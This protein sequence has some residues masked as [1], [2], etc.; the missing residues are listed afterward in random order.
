MNKSR[1]REKIQKGWSTFQTSP[2]LRFGAYTL[3]LLLFSGWASDYG[4]IDLL[5]FWQGGHWPMLV[6]SIFPTAL[7]IHT[8]CLLRLWGT[9][10]L[11]LWLLFMGSQVYILELLNYRMS[12]GMISSIFETD[13]KEAG[14]FVTPVTIAIFLSLFLFSFLFMWFM[15]RLKKDSLRKSLWLWGGLLLLTGANALLV[16]DKPSMRETALWPMNNIAYISEQVGIYWFK[17]RPLMQSLRTLPS[18]ADRE[19]QFEAFPGGLTV[20]F[21]L[22]ETGRADHWSINGYG[23]PTTPFIEEENSRGHLINFPRSLSFAAGTRLS[24]VGM[25]TNAKLSKS[26][27]S[28]GPLFDLYQKHGFA[29]QAFRSNQRSDDQ[30]YDSTLITLTRIFKGKTVYETG[31]ADRI[32]PGIRDYLAREKNPCQF[33][34]YYG[35]GSHAPYLYPEKY[36]RF[37]PDDMDPLNYAS[38]PEQLVNRYDNSIFATDHFI[39]EVISSL[40]D[41][42][43]IY[44]YASDHGEYLGE[45]GFYSHGNHVMSDPE[46]RYIP[47]FIWFSPAF[48]KARPELTR[49]LREN[50]R[51]LRVVSHDY[52]FHTTLALSGFKSPFI[53]PELDLSSP[54]AKPHEGKLPEDIPRDFIFDTLT[55]EVPN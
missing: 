53:E 3:I 45:H 27:P 51:K 7:L 50:S 8:F 31:T 10:P 52:L 48:E 54:M 23:R 2:R 41:K 19:S 28:C 38:K 1:L 15:E 24:C 16:P 35:E 46:I 9:I 20:F 14:A 11:A 17:E 43:A 5:A 47:L 22:G 25:L 29:L 39:R 4:N 18:V 42:C 33:L 44:I 37:K 12:F 34:F 30:L 55:K 40:K 36:A 21:H 6:L 26:F 32:I 13:L 49:Q